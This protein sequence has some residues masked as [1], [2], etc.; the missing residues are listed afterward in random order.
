MNLWN[1]NRSMCSIFPRLIIVGPQKTGSTALLRMLSQ[2]QHFR[3][4]K[5]SSTTYEELQF[6]SNDTLYLN[7]INWFVEEL[8]QSF[9]IRF[10]CRYLDQFST[11]P[12]D[13]PT[14]INLEKSAT[15]FD[16]L[17]VVKRIKALLPNVRLIM[18]LT[19]PGTRAY[20]RFQVE[21]NSI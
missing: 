7:G 15:Y 17:L 14:V 8:I 19:E 9:H 16:S 5:E 1:G 20:S 11:D 13:S 4:S 18:M 2:H 10:I 6:F 21:D 3:P 12:M